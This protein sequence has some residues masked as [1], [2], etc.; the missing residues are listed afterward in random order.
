MTFDEYLS[1]PQPQNLGLVCALTKV[2]GRSIVHSILHESCRI[3]TS[4]EGLV[5]TCVELCMDTGWN[6][7][8]AS[9][10]WEFPFRRLMLRAYQKLTVLLVVYVV[11]ILQ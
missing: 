5:G 6:G 8:C 2:L 7:G 10:G 3:D 11:Q 1:Q 9:L 4:P